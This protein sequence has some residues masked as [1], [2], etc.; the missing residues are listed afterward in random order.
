M[1]DSLRPHEL[2]SPWN[3]PGQNTG[4]GS[5]SLLQGIFLTQKLN[6]G[7]LHCRQILNQLSYQRSPLLALLGIQMLLPVESFLLSHLSPPVVS[8]GLWAAFSW[9]PL[10]IIRHC[11]ALCG[12]LYAVVDFFIGHNAREPP[13]FPRR[14]WENASLHLLLVQVNVVTNTE[15]SSLFLVFTSGCCCNKF[16][17]F[18]TSQIYY[19]LVV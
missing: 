19:F 6:W 14:G 9:T 10:P 8:A 1:S 13:C 12:D 11:Y 15:Q 18:L 7:L 16:G 3:S 2:Y 17:A 4:V 5:L